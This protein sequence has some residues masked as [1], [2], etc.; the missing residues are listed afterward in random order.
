MQVG[1]DVMLE[2]DQQQLRQKSMVLGTL[3]L[4]LVDQVFPG[5]PFQLRLQS[6]FCPPGGWLPAQ[7][8]PQAVG[9]C[10]KAGRVVGP[11]REEGGF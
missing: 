9:Q 6:G 7:I 2:A 11:G 4:Q 1:V 5:T 10:R 3:F 8:V